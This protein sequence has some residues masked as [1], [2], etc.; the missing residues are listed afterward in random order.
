[1][2]TVKGG[3][4]YVDFDSDPNFGAAKRIMRLLKSGTGFTPRTLTEEGADNKPMSVAKAVD[5]TIRSADVDNGVGSAYEALKA[6][7]DARTPLHFRFGLLGSSD[8]QMHSCDAAWN[9]SVN[10]N[11]LSEVDAVIKKEGANS[12]RLTCSD[13]IG[14]D[15][16]MATAVVNNSL[17]GIAGSSFWFYTNQNRLAGQ[18]QLLMSTTPN[19]A[20]PVVTIDLPDLNLNTWYFVDYTFPASLNDTVVSIGL[21]STNLFSPGTI[22]Y[23]DDVRLRGGKIATVKNVPVHVLF[24]KNE[25]GK[26]NALKV[27]GV[28]F[29]DTEANLYSNNF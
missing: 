23:I 14:P 6:A 22:F 21:K 19:C 3:Y 16:I 17:S 9:E 13:Y 15:I 26:F 4:T 5:L 27:T 2:K 8:F 28:G 10:A 18:L 24:E 20:N 25:A 12:A 1:M 29:A 11:I 7:E